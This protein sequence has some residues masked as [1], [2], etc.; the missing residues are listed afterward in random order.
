MIRYFFSSLDKLLSS[1]FVYHY[2]FSNRHT[3]VTSALPYSHFDTN[4]K[5]KIGFSTMTICSNFLSIF[6]KYFKLKIS[7]HSKTKNLFF[8]SPTR[9]NMCLL[10]YIITNIR[11]MSGNH[12][13]FLLYLC[14]WDIFKNWYSL[15]M[16]HLYEYLCYEYQKYMFQ[17]LFSLIVP[18]A[19]PNWLPTIFDLTAYDS[20]VGPKL[21]FC[22]KDKP[23]SLQLL[24]L[25][26]LK[27]ILSL[28]IMLRS[29]F[30]CLIGQEF[31]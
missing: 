25:I 3:F 13:H 29:L 21:K 23:S 20:G 27:N 26:S 8:L 31:I 24:K 1:V 6:F 11:D 15:F 4:S 22:F 18:Y 2:V 7:L 12:Q 5:L 28:L 16:V 14:I 30:L 9:V 17:K 10:Q 19:F